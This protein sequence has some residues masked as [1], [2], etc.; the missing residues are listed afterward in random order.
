MLKE[1]LIERIIYRNQEIAFI[2]RAKYPVDNV[3]FFSKKEDFLQVGCHKKSKGV[4][5]KAH[6]HQ[7]RNH[8]ISSLQ[9]VL[10][11]V[12]GIVKVNFYTNKGTLIETKILNKGDILFQRSLGHGFEILENTE[13]FEVKQGPFF[14]KEHKKFFK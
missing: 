14:G 12:K 11:I 6:Y 2:V 10:Y 1:K 7:F 3:E 8:Q 4:K 5:L 13:I 9:E